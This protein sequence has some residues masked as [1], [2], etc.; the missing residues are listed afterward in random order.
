MEITGIIAEYNPFHN[1]HLYQ[2]KQIKDQNIQEQI[3]E[4][5]AGKLSSVDLESLKKT[6]QEKYNF[7]G[8]N[9]IILISI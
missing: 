5:V 4:A 3:A 1:G 8:R 9:L 6:L 2:I 7:T